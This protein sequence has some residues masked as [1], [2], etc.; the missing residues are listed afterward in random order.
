MVRG[1]LRFGHLVV[2]PG[3]VAGLDVN[4]LL[5]TGS[6]TSLVNEALIEAIET[7]RGRRG[8][9]ER[10]ATANETITLNR[11]VVLERLSIGALEAENVV[12]FVG[13]FHIFALWGLLE[14]PTILL[15]MDVISA[16]DA[17]AIDYGRATVHF[18][19]S[20]QR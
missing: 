11:A 14:E 4:V 6:D 2:V 3:R 19:I 7:R 12:A 5:D 9:V 8:F 1:A 18:R 10:A 20:D 16:A 17:M 13:D 15:G